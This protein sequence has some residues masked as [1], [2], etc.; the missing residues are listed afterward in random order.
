MSIKRYGCINDL[1]GEIA[2]SADSR[3]CDGHWRRATA[4]SEYRVEEYFHIEVAYGA[5]AKE[6]WTDWPLRVKRNVDLLLDLLGGIVAATHSLCW[7]TWRGNLLLTRHLQ[8]C[9]VR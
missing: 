6:Q 3:C 5:I 7:A 9:G 2:S 4:L 1:P 8:H